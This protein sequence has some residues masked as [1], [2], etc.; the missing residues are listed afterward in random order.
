MQVRLLPPRYKNIYNY[1]MRKTHFLI[2]FSIFTLL[3]STFSFTGCIHPK[4]ILFG[5][6]NIKRADE[7]STRK[8]EEAIKKSPVL[9]ELDKMCADIPKPENFKFYSKYKGN[10]SIFVSQTFIS[11]AD[12]WELMKFYKPYFEENGWQ[13]VEEEGTSCKF[14]KGVYE[15]SI[16]NAT[17]MN[18]AFYSFSCKKLQSQ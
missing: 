6:E 2:A 13:L 5:K 12:Y 1:D 4:E 9:Q 8:A 14:K 11:P 3:T 17:D 18:E 10:Q 16:F 15:L 7:E